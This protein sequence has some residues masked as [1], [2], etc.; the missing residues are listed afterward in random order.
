MR[1]HSCVTAL[2]AE[3]V[4]G[5]LPLK[6]FS[7]RFLCGNVLIRVPDSAGRPHG[8]DAAYRKR[9][10]VSAVMLARIGPVKPFLPKC[11]I[12]QAHAAAQ[13]KPQ[14]RSHA[15]AQRSMRRIG[16]SKARVGAHRYVSAVNAEIVDGTAPEKR[17]S[18]SSLRH[19]VPVLMPDSAGRPHGGGA[20]YR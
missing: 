18:P 14:T 1:A 4:D 17:F 15:L 19:N 10:L 16:G 2:S 13:N 11:L 3:I 7:P 20:A 6:R 12:T 5:T 8:G 9:S